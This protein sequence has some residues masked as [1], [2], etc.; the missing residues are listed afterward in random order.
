MKPYLDEVYIP[1]QQKNI[2][3]IFDTRGFQFRDLITFK[4]FQYNLEL[5]K[6]RG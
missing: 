1:E 2:I 4:Q 5:L 6:P 3:A